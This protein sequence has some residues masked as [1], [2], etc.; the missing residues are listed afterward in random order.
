MTIFFV[1]IL[2][3]CLFRSKLFL[4]INLF[5]YFDR[6][7]YKIFF[8]NYPNHKHSVNMNKFF[9]LFFYTMDQNR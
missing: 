6:N 3:N 2:L 1:L 7:L 9:L 4:K 8:Y 5:N